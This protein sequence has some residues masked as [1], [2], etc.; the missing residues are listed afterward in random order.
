MGWVTVDERNN[1]DF[2]LRNYEIEQQGNLVT[3]NFLDSYF[4]EEE[5]TIKQMEAVTMLTDLVFEGNQMY[6][7]EALTIEGLLEFYNPCNRYKGF[8]LL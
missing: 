6:L 2:I 3:V 1:V 5:L 8:I 7:L 4:R